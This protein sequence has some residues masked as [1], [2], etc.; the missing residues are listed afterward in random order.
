MTVRAEIR[1]W[2]PPRRPGELHTVFVRAC[3]PGN[4]TG[5]QDLE[6]WLELGGGLAALRANPNPFKSNLPALA[7]AIELRGEKAPPSLRAVLGF[8][9]MVEPLRTTR[10]LAIIERL[11]G[12]MED[13]GVSSL[14]GGDA[15]TAQIAYPKAEARHITAVT[16]IAE[17]QALPALQALCR[18][19]GFVQER[20]LGGGLELK[21]ASGARVVLL[22]R[23][24]PTDRSPM[25]D[26]LLADRS[27]GLSLLS[28]PLLFV[29]CCITGYPPIAASHVP[30]MIDAAMLASLLSSDEWTTVAE[31]R[32]RVPREPLLAALRY[33][34]DALGVPV[35][36]K[37]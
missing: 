18:A 11:N 28:T 37:I 34:R 10:Y 8:T 9:Q 33:L 12:L 6:S 23:L 26:E 27:G 16:I 14:L 22:D 13:A 35:P 4:P 25:V 1:R 21:A 17:T 2:L 29:C 15:A 7:Y 24:F 19:D 32:A 36:L 20:T 31:L 5:A 30:A 3:L